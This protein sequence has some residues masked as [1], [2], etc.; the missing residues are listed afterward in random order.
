[1][2]KFIL[3]W[4]EKLAWVAFW[5]C[6][7]VT[8]F[9]YFPAGLGGGT[10]VRPLSLYPLLI[11]LIIAVIPSLFR[12]PLPK[13]VL[14]LL[15]FVA[16][17]LISAAASTWLGI[18][19]VLGVSVSDRIIRALITLAIGISFYLTVVLL[20]DNPK[21]FYSALRWMMLGFGIAFVW[22]SLQVVYILHFNPVLF[23]KLNRIQLLFS[24]RKLFTTRIS[25][26][27]YEPNWFGEQISV[28]LIPW[29]V[30]AIFSGQ[31]I[32]PWRWR[33]ITLEWFILAWAVVMI[34]FTFSR[35]AYI[36]LIA[37]GLAAVVL[38]RKPPARSDRKR[39]IWGIIKKGGEVVIVLL[40]FVVGGYMVGK[41]NVFFSRIW[42][43]WLE[44][45]DTS[46]EDYFQYLGFGARLAYVNTALNTFQA[47]PLFGVGPGNY[48]FFFEKMLPDQPLAVMPELLRIISPE[49]G[50]NRLIT[51]KNLYLRILAE[52]GL[53]GMATFCA[54][55]AAL[56]GCSLFLW[57]SKDYEE[58]FWGG[59]A[60]LGLVVLALA[61]FSFDSFALP[62]MW[63]LSG[64]I[65]AGS[66]Q[67]YQRGRSSLSSTS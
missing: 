32:F 62:N 36:N 24:I 4:I 49:E 52:G 28:L 57:F 38:F 35:A 16:A 63:V 64:L 26:M 11:L 60:L 13:T 6:L 5:L 67:A 46:L 40:V 47:Y 58:H 59:A 3:S 12:R 33:K 20:T 45:K 2:L 37:I 44:K 55:L 53:F 9:R 21:K 17:L 51:P 39:S 29:L 31:T 42:G 19:P 18:E 61:A 14:T 1:M 27:T 22:G 48:A 7:P 65:T 8:S 25:G 15:P 30:A 34:G 50:R 43:Y 66:W 23:A 41:N 10:L 54:F 56:V